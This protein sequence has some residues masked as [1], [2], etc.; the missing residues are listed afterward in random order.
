MV[1]KVPKSIFKAEVTRAEHR[2]P[3]TNSLLSGIEHAYA[4]FSYIEHPL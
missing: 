1:L 4:A 2:S 3:K